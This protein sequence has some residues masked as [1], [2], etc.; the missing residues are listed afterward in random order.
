MLGL[1]A[2]GGC[3]CSKRKAFLGGKRIKSSAASKIPT[4]RQRLWADLCAIA[5]G[6]WGVQVLQPRAKLK[7]RLQ[8]ARRLLTRSLGAKR[9]PCVQSPAAETLQEP[10]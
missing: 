9:E 2:R 3:F 5:S 6:R 7:S 10:L 8:T 1:G 4:K